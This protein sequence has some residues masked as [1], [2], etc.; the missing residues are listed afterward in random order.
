MPTKR[1][2]PPTRRTAA[3]IAKEKRVRKKFQRE[4]PSLDDLLKQIK[5]EVKKP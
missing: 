1:I 5:F 2:P 3:Q 4:K